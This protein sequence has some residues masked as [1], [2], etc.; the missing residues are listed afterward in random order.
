MPVAQRRDQHHRTRE[1]GE[2]CGSDAGTLFLCSRAIV[3][4]LQRIDNGPHRSGGAAQGVGVP[5]GSDAAGAARA[6][7][8]NPL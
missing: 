2:G 3:D 5:K 1:V 8:S 4:L 7:R 6:S